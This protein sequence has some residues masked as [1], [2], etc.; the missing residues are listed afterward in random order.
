MKI[1]RMIAQVLWLLLLCEVIVQ[2]K[3]DRG[4]KG[5][6][7]P[8]EPLYLTPLIDAGRL[9]EARARSKTGRIGGNDLENVLS[10]SG[11]LTVNR[12]L[13]SNLFFWFVPAIKRRDKAPVLAWLQGGPGSSSLV[14]FIVENGPYTLSTDGSLKPIRRKA[15][16]A[17]HFSM[18][19]VDEPVGA[20]FSFTDSDEGYARNLTDVGQDMLEFLQQFFQLFHDYSQNDF[21]VTGE[22]FGGK[23]V[24]ATAFA[25]HE[26]KDSLR[27]KINLK[28]IAYG[29]GFTDPV[30]QLNISDWIYHLGL[31][32]RHQAAYFN[33][34]YNVAKN[35]INDG[36]YT[37][38]FFVINELMFALPNDYYNPP[39][40]YFKNVTGYGSYYNV[41][42]LEAP[43]I[44]NYFDD[45][46]EIESV[47][48]A[49]HV[50]SNTFNDRTAVVTHLIDDLM[51]SA[52]PYLPVLMNNYKVLLYGGQLDIVVPYTSTVAFVSTIPWSGAEE[53]EAAPSR[54][55][56]PQSLTSGSKVSSNHVYGYVRTAGKVILVMVRNAGHYVP[57]DQ[58]EAALDMITRFINDLPFS[59]EEMEDRKLIN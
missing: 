52:K 3:A 55:W 40:T 20:G 45:F 39:S 51:N 21:Y 18:L 23:F 10:Y 11:Y 15:T 4:D 17:T 29:N 24:P 9:E 50:G 1:H 35:Y 7:G 48:R 59:D 5:R 43:A 54:I 27:V 6:G 14:G 44:R 41:L 19:Y 53:L 28:G 8:G 58:P 25:I 12:E 22:S 46:V 56:R 16:W 37:D 33:Q 38:A 49:I 47:R 42:L 57:L 30:I 13:N 36:H 26:A 34:K 31:F 2:G 32:D